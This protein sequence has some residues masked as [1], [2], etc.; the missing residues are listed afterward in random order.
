MGDAENLFK[1]YELEKYD[2]SKRAENAEKLSVLPVT[3]SLGGISFFLAL[4]NT[5]LI[6]SNLS[7]L[8][9]KQQMTVMKEMTKQMASMNIGAGLQQF[10]ISQV[11][12]SFQSPEIKASLN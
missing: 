4:A 6:G 2:S 3:M 9:P 1:Y 12:P 8:S 10:I 5:S 11:L 7:S